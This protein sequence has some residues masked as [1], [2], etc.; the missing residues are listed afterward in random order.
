MLLLV[1]GVFHPGP[2]LKG[3]KKT[4]TSWMSTSCFNDIG[5]MLVSSKSS[6]SRYP[7]GALG[8]TAV[9]RMVPKKTS[10]IGY[11]AIFLA[12]LVLLSTGRATV[13]SE[14]ESAESRLLPTFTDISQEAGLNMTMINGDEPTLY[15]M[16]VNGTGA[17]FLDYNNDGFQ[18]IFLV[19]GSSRKSEAQG[20]HPHDYLLRNNGDG[21]F[22]DVTKQAHLGESGWH[23]GCAV[24]DYNNDGFSDIY[25]TSYGA[26]K[27]YRNN[28]D[29]TFTDVAAAAHVDDPHWAYPKWS[30]G[31]AW[32]DYDNDGKIDLYVANF[33]RVDPQHL[34]PKP[35]DPE[36]CK[37]VD[38]PI[39]C[40]PDRYY[41]EQGILYHNNGDGTFTDVTQKAGLARAD[42]DQGRGFGVV[43]GDFANIGRQDI[44]QVN[45]SGMSCFYVNNGDGTFRDASFESGLALD[46]FGNVHGTMGVTVGDYN[47]DGL[48]DIFIANWIQQGNDLYENQG[49][50]VFVDVSAARGIEQLGYEYCGWGT[51]L[52]DFDNDGWLDLWITFGH[53]DPQVGAAHP[54]HP[55]AEPNYMLRSLE[56]K[57]F[58]DVSEATGLRRL[59]NRS[60]RGVAFGDFDN[61]GDVDVLIIDKNSTPILLRNDGGN[62]NNWIE[63]RAEGVQSNRSGIG[64]RITVNAGG[65]RRIF[66]VRNNESYLSSNDLRVPI[67]MGNMKQADSVE[68][69]WPN[70]HIDRSENVAVNKFYWARE[71]SVLKPDP[72]V[73]PMKTHR[74]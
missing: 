10:W 63:I 72:Q 47:N 22:T 28:G 12:A 74:P 33:A 11:S 13:N 32:G 2:P 70:G 56:G 39:A 65:K 16:D 18:D 30:M 53:T 58:E 3:N 26:N 37:N 14:I 25:L 15:L 55:Y 27:L 41:G 52:F 61:D 64:A 44:Y 4:A 36:P 40:P 38:V 62:R 20:I 50:H 35:G 49:S 42:K 46:G 8:E 9:M 68:V 29:G 67:G 48:M 1:N 45:D 17:C 69:R 43:F 31:A 73:R 57:R 51:R 21:T 59:P 5:I 66:D 34:L 6:E 54:D 23:S 24:A 19:N 60:G 71:G 7:L